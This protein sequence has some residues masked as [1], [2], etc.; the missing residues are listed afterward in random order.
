MLTDRFRPGA[1]DGRL[2]SPDKVL[3]KKWN[4]STEA[5]RLWVRLRIHT[6]GQFLPVE[7][8]ERKFR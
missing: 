3:G 4:F 8:R 5:D 1:A 2:Y 7:N 6:I